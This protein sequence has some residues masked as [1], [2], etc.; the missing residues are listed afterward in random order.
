[1]TL[2]SEG[3]MVDKTDSDPAPEQVLSHRKCSTKAFRMNKKMV[4]LFLNSLLSEKRADNCMHDP[5]ILSLKSAGSQAPNWITEE[6]PKAKVLSQMRPDLFLKPLRVTPSHAKL[7]PLP[8]TRRVLSRLCYLWLK[9]LPQRHLL[10]EN[11]LAAQ[12]RP[13]VSV[14]AARFS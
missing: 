1:M 8:R 6:N 3:P 4:S 14:C 13:P 9:A 2:D 11:M 12:Q 5:P 10:Q 7:H